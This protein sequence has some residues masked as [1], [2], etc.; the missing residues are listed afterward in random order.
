M[1]NDDTALD[2]KSVENN[3]KCEQAHPGPDICCVLERI[4]DVPTDCRCNDPQYQHNRHKFVTNLRQNLLEEG[5]DLAGPVRFL[6][7]LHRSYLE[8]H[9]LTFI[10]AMMASCMSGIKGFRSARTHLTIF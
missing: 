6:W 3:D 9:G 10:K 8:R 4:P 2:E 5:R 7:V 1:L